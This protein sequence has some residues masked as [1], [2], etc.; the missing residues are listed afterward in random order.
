MGPYDYN[1]YSEIFRQ[2][3][4]SPIK[5]AFPGRIAFC[6]AE[7]VARAH[8][9]AYERAVPG[10]HY[11]LGGTYASWLEMSKQICRLLGVREPRRATP[12]WVLKPVAHAMNAF[13]SLSGKKPL[14][15]PELLSLLHDTD[16][17][18]PAD[19]EKARDELGYQSR[20]LEQMVR[21]CFEWMKSEGRL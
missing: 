8:L 10:S 1:S 19:R 7:D 15:T 20:P 14:L 11:T 12:G 3:K 9:Q 18:T 4:N 13:A 6:H 2:L 16:D 5:T 17:V 21:D